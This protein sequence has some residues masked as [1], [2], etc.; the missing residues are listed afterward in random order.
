MRV[1][2]D[3]AYGKAAD[4]SLVWIVK[5]NEGAAGQGA[6]A[7]LQRRHAKAMRRSSIAAW[8]LAF[9]VGLVAVVQIV[10]QVTGG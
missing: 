6:L 7:E 3:N 8:W 1:G 10:V 2:H 4:E 5:Q 9:A